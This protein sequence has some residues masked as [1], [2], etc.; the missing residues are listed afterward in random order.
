MVPIDDLKI[1]PLNPRRMPA[2]ELAA[3]ERS[4]TAFGMVEPIVARWGEG[5]AI[6]G[7]QRLVAAKRLGWSE[8]PVVWVE[9][10]DT[11]AQA[12]NLAL[13]KID[14]EWDEAKLGAVLAELADV[15]SLSGALTGFDPKL[16]ELAGFTTREVLAAI[17]AHLGDDTANEDLTA[18]ALSLAAPTKRETRAKPG[19]LYRLG[20]HSVLCGDATDINAVRLLCEDCPP[21]MLF[22]D[23]PYGV[24]YDPEGGPGRAASSGRP[25]R[26]SGRQLGSILGDD[27]SAEGHEHLITGSLRNAVAVLSPGASV[28]VC[29]GTST[30][31]VYDAA[32]EAAGIA[33]SS[34]IVWDKSEFTFGRKDYSSQFELITYG[35]VRGAAHSFY[36]GRGQTD[37]WVIPRDP[38]AS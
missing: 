13:N 30:T 33:K 25:V 34:I 3:L 15:D 18:L 37:I 17:E 4:I 19:D 32:F 5:T 12:L 35:W 11:E 2:S 29:G 31:S 6:G 9:V 1:D 26:N 28:Y 10:S 20:P 38:T 7:N 23:P 8:V 14:G 27:L 22:T 36:G 21:A 24:A 16:T